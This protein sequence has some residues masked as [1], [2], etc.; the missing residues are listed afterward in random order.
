MAFFFVSSVFFFFSLCLAGGGLYGLF[1]FFLFPFVCQSLNSPLP[2]QFHFFFIRFFSLVNGTICERYP[3]SPPH[4]LSLLTIP[5]LSRPVIN[6]WLRG[7][8]TFLY[9]HKNT[10]EGD[11]RKQTDEQ[12]RTNLGLTKSRGWYR[13]TIC[14]C[15]PD[16]IYGLT[17]AWVTSENSTMLLESDSSWL[18]VAGPYLVSSP[19]CSGVWCWLPLRGLQPQLPSLCSPATNSSPASRRQLSF[20][21]PYH[22]RIRRDFFVQASFVWFRAKTDSSALAAYPHSATKRKGT[23][24]GFLI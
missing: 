2:D 5:L 14:M 12:T 7:Q 22:F 21:S 16:S 23:E 3:L 1:P 18:T 24:A 6:Q 17:L 10:I 20:A 19:L 9:L 8:R 4:Y 11:R 13:N 15:I